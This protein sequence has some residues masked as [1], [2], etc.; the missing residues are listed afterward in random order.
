MKKKIIKEINLCKNWEETINYIIYLS[1][2]LPLN[3]I[4]IRKKKYIIYGCYNNIWLKINK[5]KKKIIINGDS[6]T[7]I[8]KGILFIILSFYNKKKKNY[9]LKLNLINLLKKIKL[10]K[11]IDIT[12][13]II[14]KKIILFIKKKIKKI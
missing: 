2:K 4:N 12:K 11:Y 8:I 3:N 9:I 5:I 14:I 10:F 6:N 13:K 1:K 7:I